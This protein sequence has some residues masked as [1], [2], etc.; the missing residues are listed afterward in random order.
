M[1]SLPQEL[2]DEIIG[3]LPLDRN[4]LSNCSLV[5]EPWRDISQ[6]RLFRS[7]KTGPRNLRWWLDDISRK[8]IKLLG[9]V[10]ELTCFMEEL[11]TM[12]QIEPAHDTLQGHSPLLPQ[13][14]HFTLWYTDVQSLSWTR[15]ISDFKYSL[16]TITLF[17]CT[18]SNVAL[19]ALINYFPNLKSL[20]LEDLSYTNSHESTSLSSRTF[21]EKLYVR[22][23]IGSSLDLLKELSE[24]GLCS[25][26]VALSVS[27]LPDNPSTTFVNRVVRAFGASVKFLRLPQMSN[28][29]SNPSYFYSG[30]S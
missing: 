24:L 19:V 15:L 9:Y 20:Y 4:L 12:Q 16:F 11:F 6:K 30:N 10:R 2:I 22:D 5:A 21:L 25:E 29:M 26:E 27:A 7:I 28:S 23:Y 13:L 3:F 1:D 14:K 8:N 18:V 17:H